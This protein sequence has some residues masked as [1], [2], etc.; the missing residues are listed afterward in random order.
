MHTAAQGGR[1]DQCFPD[2]AEGVVSPGFDLLLHLPLSHTTSHH[3]IS[4]SLSL[5][6]FLSL[7]RARSRTLFLS[8]FLSLAHTHIPTAQNVVHARAKGADAEHLYR[9]SKV[10]LLPSSPDPC[11]HS[12][13]A[14]APCHWGH[15]AALHDACSNIVLITLTRLL[16]AIA[17]R[18]AAD[19]AA[20]FL[21]R[22]QRPA[23]H[24][25][26]VVLQA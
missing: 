21:P 17:L 20:T 18:C 1:G 15:W 26:E 10:G 12:C 19:L 22:V 9:R 6:L 23:H 4:L 14:P 7:S 2:G 3:P 25:A 24:G 13:S 16:R 5:S 11:L 8:I